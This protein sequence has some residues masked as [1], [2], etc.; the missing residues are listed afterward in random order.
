MKKAIIAALLVIAALIYGINSRGDREIAV[1]TLDAD[2]T[3]S[4]VA[5]TAKQLVEM[6]ITPS[7]RL[8]PVDSGVALLICPLPYSLIGCDTLP[9]CSR[10]LE[11]F[12][13]ASI[14]GIPA[15]YIP[16]GGSPPEIVADTVVTR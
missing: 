9:V 10:T 6:G 2:D 15:R 1:E 5:L 3:T 12:P 4:I 16:V 11:T 14:T 8:V 7:Y 13:C